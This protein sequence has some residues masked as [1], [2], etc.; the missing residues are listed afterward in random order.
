MYISRV[1]L[2]DIRGF[3][4]L[5]FSFEHAP[6]QFSGWTVITGDNGSGKSTLLKAIAIALNGPNLARVLQ[7]S[8]RGWVNLGSERGT[9][10]V[11]LRRAEPDDSFRE[12]G[13]AS[14]KIWAE[15]EL[16][17]TEKEPLLKPI[18]KRGK[19][20]KGPTRGPWSE[21]PIGW[22]SCGYGP[23][24]R[25]YGESPDAQ[26]IMSGPG[27]VARYATMFREAASLAESERWV[28]ELHFRRLEADVQSIA[29]LEALTALLNDDFLQNGMKVQRIDT[30]GLWLEDQSGVVLPLED[31]SDGYRSAVALLVDII[32]HMT[33]VY[34]Y[35]DLVSK[36]QR[37]EI[38][39]RRS[40]VV[41]IDE[42]DGHLHPKWQ[43][44]IGFWLKRRFPNLQFIVTS[45]S[46]F[47]C[48][49]ADPRGLFCLPAPGSNEKPYQISDS[50]YRK[51]VLAKPNEIL[52]SPSFNLRHT[53]SPL[54]VRQEQR[55]SQLI[56]RKSAGALGQSEAAELK[57]LESSLHPL[58]AEVS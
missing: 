38:I 34:G 13:K 3:R 2:E 26:R 20:R 48:Q 17:K 43:R 7:P 12:V 9:I 32:R 6:E 49:A 42:V 18:R 11:E 10:S 29:V 47:I 45:H 36:N 55:Y 41:L 50:E 23:F 44:E 40:G 35:D 30:D 8:F 33:S 16:T 14:P 51:I 22:F 39:V 28:R 52:I 24:R 46:A 15:I 53:R 1:V 4:K 57:D 37:D 56:A 21:N 5:E 27:P 54:V 31:M 58:F 19:Q 25:L